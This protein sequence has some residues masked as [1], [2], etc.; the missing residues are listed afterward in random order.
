MKRRTGLAAARRARRG[1]PAGGVRRRRRLVGDHR[2]GDARRPPRP[3][4]GHDMSHTM[5]ATATA[6]RRCSPPP[7]SRTSRPPRRPATPARWTRSAA[8]RTRPT[9]GMGVHYINQSLMDANVDIT[10]PEALVYELDA[11]GQITG[12]VAHEYI[13][14][15]RRLEVEAAAEAVRHGAS[16]STR[17]CRCGCCTRGS[18]R[19]TRPASS[20]T[21][22]RPCGCARPACRSSARTSRRRPPPTRRRR[23]PRAPSRAATECRD[24]ATTTPGPRDPA[25]SRSGQWSSEA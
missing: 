15:D 18:G 14:P 20:R 6:P 5:T 13:V 1:R 21:G 12:L 22:T 19:T 8:S 7:A 4:R 24:L 2:T 17:R 16:T 23:P 10:K 11:T 3:C 9:G 25:S